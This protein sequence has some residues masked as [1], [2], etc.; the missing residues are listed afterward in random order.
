MDSSSKHIEMQWE[1]TGKIL[2]AVISQLQ[3]MLCSK[4]FCVLAK[5]LTG[6]VH[7]FEMELHLTIS[8]F[9]DYAVSQTD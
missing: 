5:R 6:M 3:P 1:I 9:I 4:I 8:D 7:G 2:P